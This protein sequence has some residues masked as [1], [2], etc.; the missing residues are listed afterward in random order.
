MEF[1]KTLGTRA[2]IDFE[3]HTYS[4][5]SYHNQSTRDQAVANNSK[6]R[7]VSIE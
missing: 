4:V 2:N 1:S 7:L 5:A 3:L 6:S